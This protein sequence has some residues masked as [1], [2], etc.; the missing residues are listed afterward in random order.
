LQVP[1]EVSLVCRGKAGKRRNP[2]RLGK[3]GEEPVLNKVGVLFL[4]LAKIF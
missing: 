3:S 2:P 4:H 1:S